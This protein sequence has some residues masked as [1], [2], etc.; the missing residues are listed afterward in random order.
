MM[1]KSNQVAT[2]KPLEDRDR[3]D[4]LNGGYLAVF[5]FICGIALVLA[6]FWVNIFF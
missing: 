4:F 2:E 1:I 3:K 6:F 5:S